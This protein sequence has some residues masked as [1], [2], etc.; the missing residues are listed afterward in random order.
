MLIVRLKKNLTIHG[1]LHT[2][3]LKYIFC[4]YPNFFQACILYVHTP[5]KNISHTIHFINDYY[6]YKNAER[7][8]F[9]HEGHFKKCYSYTLFT[10]YTLLLCETWI[11][12]ILMKN[13]KKFI[14]QNN[15]FK[16]FSIIFKS[17]TLTLLLLLI[18]FS[19]IFGKF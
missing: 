12:F 9:I 5:M 8:F 10:K 6:A 4:I 14:Y 19:G 16:F 7:K 13:K 18:N 11:Y 3:S 2:C 17:Y 15:Q 1:M